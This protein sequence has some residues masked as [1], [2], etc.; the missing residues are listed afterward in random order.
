[1][2][3]KLIYFKGIQIPEFEVYV[4][5]ELERLTEKQFRFVA[6]IC[7]WRGYKGEFYSKETGIGE[8]CFT[9]KENRVSGITLDEC[10]L[11]S[12]PRSIEKL[13]NLEVLDLQYNNLTEF[14]ESI[15]NLTSLRTLILS[16]NN[17]IEIPESISNLENLENLFIKHN[18]LYSLPE[19]IC[20]LTSLERLNLIGNPIKIPPEDL[21]NF[22]CTIWK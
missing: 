17:L 10:N 11:T 6:S 14:P 15:S 13:Q 4:L 20:E 1:M 9:V 12:L 22:S 2:R 16:F 19:S 21:D 3:D 18:L 8:L 5:Q 7:K